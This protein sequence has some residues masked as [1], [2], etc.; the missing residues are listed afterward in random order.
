MG[1]DLV[2]QQP[3][4]KQLHYN[5]AGWEFIT[6]KLEQWGIDISEFDG[7]NDGKLIK[8]RTCKKVAAAIELHLEELD[9][10]HRAWLEPHIDKWRES[11]G[12]QQW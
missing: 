8:E 3:N 7:V 11:G 1:M 9:E 2:P 10:A 5:W 12:F 6:N 4:A